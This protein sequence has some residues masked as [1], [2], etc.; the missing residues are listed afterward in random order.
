MVD[1]SYLGKSHTQVV[2][3]HANTFR[4]MA[5]THIAPTVDPQDRFAQDDDSFPGLWTTTITCFTH[6][7]ERGVWK[8]V[9]DKNKMYYKL[10]DND[11]NNHW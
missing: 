3:W 4:H 6:D 2:E 7:S 11:P 9:F 5:Y 8:L 1:K 10:I